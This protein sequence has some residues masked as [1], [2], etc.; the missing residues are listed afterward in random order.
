VN[1]LKTS[2]KRALGRVGYTVQHLPPS[3]HDPRLALKIDFKY[4]LAHYLASR[5]DTRSF[6]FLQVGALD[7]VVD[8]PLHRY[9]RARNWH[10]ILV[11]PQPFH[12]RRLVENYA[13][14]EDLRFVNAAIT[15]QVGLRDLYVIQDEAGVTIESLGGVAFSVKTRYAYP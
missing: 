12:F 3:R 5:V 11:E 15:E 1:L 2:I 8:D 9:V 4:V 13:G 14:L 6:F 7:G 10:G